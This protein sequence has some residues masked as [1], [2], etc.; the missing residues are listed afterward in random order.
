MVIVRIVTPQTHVRLQFDKLS[1]KISDRGATL[2]DRI[3][4]PVWVVI[5]V[6]VLSHAMQMR[7]H[8][9][10]N[11]GLARWSGQSKALEVQFA[12]VLAYDS[13]A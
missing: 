10:F 5:A 8:A 6:R 11:H 4:V 13:N 9:L 1:K 12:P 2:P 3:A 7:K